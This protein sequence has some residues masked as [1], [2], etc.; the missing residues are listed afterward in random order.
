MKPETAT[1]M[2]TETRPM[3]PVARPSLGE[4]EAAAARE[5]ILSGWVTQG[6]QVAA[7]EREFA[8][9]VGAAHACA[10][11]SCTTALHLAL[12]ALGVGPGD[13][14]VTVSHS[15]IATANAVRYCGAEPVF[16]DIDPRTYN[17]DP[18][19]LEAAITPRA[20]A[21]VPVHQMGLP[22]D[23]AAV[24]AVAGRH[25]LPV[26]EDAACAV[27]SE[28][29]VGDRW[30]RIGRPHGAVACFSFHPRKV[31]TTGDGGMLSTDD[32]ALDARF[33]LL[34][35]HAMSVSDTQRH[36]A[37]AVV[38]EEY[39]EVGF[40]YRMTDIQAAVG[41]VQ[42]GK[43]PAMLD[44]RRALAEAYTRA[45]REIPGL[46]P[47]HVPGGARP[48][49]QSYAVRVTPGYPLSRDAL[50]Q[51]MLDAGVSTR[52]GIM[53]A[54]QEPAYHRR[55][56]RGE[57]VRA[58]PPF[59]AAQGKQGEP[60]GEPSASAR[61]NAHPPLPHSEAARDGVILLPLF[62]ALTED[63]QERVIGLLR[64]FAGERPRKRRLI[65]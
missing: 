62:D 27:G 47:P 5:A 25:G 55:A 13:E 46:E 49:Y 2:R 40:N 50:M 59:A 8:A 6:P 51:A 4:E 60:S 16:V 56:L 15:F 37:K 30:E 32:A 36:A 19:R 9:Y 20:K 57:P 65:N 26:V 22:C 10:V 28:L 29:R 54:H 42:L 48:N 24:L 33:R 64:R 58:S 44:R 39:P 35:Q 3:I 12:H 43:L 34:R 45:V 11:S 38:F 21:I 14:V 1:L 23:M 61:G 18:A 53:N 31:L 52:R 7:F 17:L 63:E 41:R